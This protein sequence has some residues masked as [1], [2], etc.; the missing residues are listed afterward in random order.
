MTHDR[1][2]ACAAEML[3]GGK[4]PAVLV[5]SGARKAIRAVLALARRRG[6]PIL[7]TP[8]AKSLIDETS[9][10]AAGVFSFGA[11][12]YANAVIASADTVVAVGT[13]LGEFSSRGGTALIGK[14]VIQ[15]VDD[16]REVAMAVSANVV[17]VGDI[18]VITRSLARILLPP[19]KQTWF[20]Q[21]RTQLRR[22][23]RS[24]ARR[25]GG[26]DPCA[27]VAAIDSALP[28]RARLACD[29]TSA[30][31]IVLRE[32]RL[33]PRRR[34]WTSLEKSACMGSALP[35]GI[36]LRI[37]SGLPTVVLIGDWGMMMGQSE[38]HTIAS[39]GLG[40]LVI[41]VW[42]N[43]G[44]ALIRCGVQ[45]QGLDAPA[46]CHTWDRAPRFELVARGYGL[47]AVTVRTAPRLRQTLARAL[48]APCPVLIDA[49]IDPASNVPAADRYVH[50]TASEKVQ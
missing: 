12:D 47:R 50:L 9:Y 20:Q 34:L 40:K 39:L 18:E 38:L 10:E 42:S 26:M 43:S 17:L 19:G 2:L 28:A 36:G 23:R 3:N 22:P 5:G 46:A 31:L 37:A 6:A 44:G 8:G 7:T 15:I 29:I 41:V 11:N 4:A 48:A 13:D 21:L 30:T 45:A 49:I 16:P 27:A 32:M 14:T 35:A 25:G 33:G 1:Y 24:P